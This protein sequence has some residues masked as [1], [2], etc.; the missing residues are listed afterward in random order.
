MRGWPTIVWQLRLRPVGS[1]DPIRVALRWSRQRPLEVWL[2][3]PDAGVH[4]VVARELLASG[5]AGPAGL[6]DVMLLPDLRDPAWLELIL[7]SPD[8]VVGLRL[9]AAELT[10]FLRATWVQ[11]PADHEASA[12]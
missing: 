2:E 4:W 10:D 3:F 9:P 6:G 5:L 11:V 7:S 1:A 12:P 8:G